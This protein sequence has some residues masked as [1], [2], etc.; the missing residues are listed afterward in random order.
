[1]IELFHTLCS[2]QFAWHCAKSLNAVVLVQLSI[3]VD[4]SIYQSDYPSVLYQENAEDQ[5]LAD[6]TLINENHIDN[7]AS[8]GIT[9]VV[10]KTVQLMEHGLLMVL[11]LTV[12]ILMQNLIAQ[13]Q[14]KDQSLCILML[15]QPMK[16]VTTLVVLMASVS[17]LEFT[18]NIS[19]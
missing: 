4:I 2:Q 3:I 11:I 14:K 9:F 6:Y 7:K 19:F 15:I 10:G 13:D 5:C 18:E 1:M 17:V 16:M 12:I 8:K